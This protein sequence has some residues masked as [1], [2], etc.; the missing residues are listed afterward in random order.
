M[1]KLLTCSGPWCCVRTAALLPL[2]IHRS[3]FRKAVAQLRWHLPSSCGDVG[4]FLSYQ[5]VV[6]PLLS[7]KS[8]SRTTV[9]PAWGSWHFRL[10][11]LVALGAGLRIASLLVPP[12]SG[13][14]HASWGTTQWLCFWPAPRF[15]CQGKAVQETQRTLRGGTL[16]GN[17][18]KT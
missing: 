2:L 17:I 7:T 12:W 8:W 16:T 11:I 15:R 18:E 6:L 3:S 4:L 13:P 10:E 1:A 5:R 14:R 9:L